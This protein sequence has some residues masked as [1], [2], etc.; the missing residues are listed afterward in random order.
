MNARMSVG[1]AGIDRTWGR[2]WRMASVLVNASRTK[3]GS[4]RY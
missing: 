1:K 4:A 2:D 3:M